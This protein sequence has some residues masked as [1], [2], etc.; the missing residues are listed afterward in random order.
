MTDQPVRVETIAHVISSRT[1]ATDDY[2]GGIESVIRLRDDLPLETLQGLDAFSHIGV[3]WAF[4]MST[5]QD[6]HLGARSP[7]N[8][9]GWEPSGAFSHRNHRRPSQIAV[10]HPRLL[11]VEDRDIHVVDLDAIHGTPVI[12]L[13]PWFEEF[14]PRGDIR[15]HAHQSTFRADGP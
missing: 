15:H 5:R 11:K 3:V 13:A 7:R 9:P 12:D 8:N 10:S 4:H 14:G 6:V 2:W 1:E